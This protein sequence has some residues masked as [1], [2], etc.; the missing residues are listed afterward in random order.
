MKRFHVLSLASALALALAVPTFSHA[1]TTHAK[2]HH[3]SAVNAGSTVASTPSSQTSATPAAAGKKSS[4]GN[5]VRHS[6]KIDLNSA[7]KEQLMTLPG[8]GDA[9]AD[10]II[11]GRPFRA[12]DELVQKSIVTKAEYSKISHRVIAKQAPEAKTESQEKAAPES[13]GQTTPEKK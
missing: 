5:A 2:A 1:A 9:T 3:P 7:T 8:I 10:K 6:E 4:K 11:A 13:Q 12:K